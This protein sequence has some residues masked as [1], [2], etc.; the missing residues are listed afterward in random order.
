VDVHGRDLSLRH[1]YPELIELCDDIPGSVAAVNGGLLVVVGG[2]PV[3]GMTLDPEGR[4]E[5]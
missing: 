2:D 3:F 5:V 1:A 4:S